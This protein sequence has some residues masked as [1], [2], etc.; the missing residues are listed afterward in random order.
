MPVR[1]VAQGDLHGKF[2]RIGFKGFDY[3]ISVGD[4][5]PNLS[6]ELMFDT[7][8]K[9]LE[10]PAFRG[11]W[12][13]SIGIEEARRRNRAEL[14]RG[15]RVIEKLLSFG[16]PVIGIPG[17]SD[18]FGPEANDYPDQRD[19]YHG[20]LTS[21][22]KGYR[23]VH[24]KLVEFPYFT[25]I[26]YGGTAGPEVPVDEATRRVYGERG[27]R[28]MERNFQGLW[29]KFDRMFIRAK[30]LPLPVILLSHNVPYETE[31]DVVKAKDSPR[32]GQ[33]FGS[34]LVRRLIEKHQPLICIGGHMH[35]SR[36]AC[37]IG[38][39]LCIN[40]G[41]GPDASMYFELRGMELSNLKS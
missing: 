36:G 20:V 19:H 26:G 30:K 5:C 25:V 41:V 24:M 34:I 35:E 13:D 9:R 1:I 29:R 6:Q 2:A 21:G 15:R 33:H 17:N 37:Y 4:F 10:N 11:E 23:D 40:P 8:K 22:L 7:L 18:F 27:T 31:L 39:T 12:W 14:E 3:I 16:K 38:D 28:R 32:H